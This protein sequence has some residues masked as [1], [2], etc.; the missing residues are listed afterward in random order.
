MLQP[1]S[2]NWP[3]QDS[4]VEIILGDSREIGPS[5]PSQSVDAIVSDP[6]YGEGLTQGDESPGDSFELLKEVLQAVRHTL[7]PGAHVALFSSSRSVNLTIEACK[8]AGLEFCRLWYLYLPSGKARPYLGVLPRTQPI[9]LSK[10]P[11]R[12][13]PKWRV[14]PAKLIRMALKSKGW[15]AGDLARELGCN[16]RLVYKWIRLDDP[17]WSYPSEKHQD[18]L[19]RLLGVYLPPCPEKG[20]VTY[21]HDIFRVTRGVAETSHPCEKPLE[22]VEDLV[23]RLAAPGELVLDPF[24]GS[25]TTVLAA[26]RLGIRAVGIECD[27]EYFDLSTDRVSSA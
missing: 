25:G 6:P 9:V 15:S 11:G 8:S 2:W 12:K 27:Q 14:G 5:L 24:L 22:V 18:A 21:R 1:T 20:T 23:G 4:G 16:Q 17:A 19:V 13:L 26:Q 7:K 10:A 3:T